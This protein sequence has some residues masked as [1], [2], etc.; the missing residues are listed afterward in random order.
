MGLLKTKVGVATFKGLTL[1]AKAIAGPVGANRPARGQLGV[2]RGIISDIDPNVR[3]VN[4]IDEEDE[5]EAVSDIDKEL[6]ALRDRLDKLKEGV[7]EE[8]DDMDFDI[9]EDEANILAEHFNLPPATIKLEAQR[10]SSYSSKREAGGSLTALFVPPG[11]T[12]KRTY[13]TQKSEWTEQQENL[14]L[15][16]EAALSPL[17]PEDTVNSIPSEASHELDDSSITTPH[18]KEN[19]LALVS[20]ELDVTA[21]DTSDEGGV[22]KSLDV[23]KPD[24]M[25]TLRSLKGKCT[26]TSEE[27]SYAKALPIHRF[28]PVVSMHENKASLT[29]SSLSFGHGRKPTPHPSD[30]GSSSMA[31]ATIQAGSVKGNLMFTEEKLNTIVAA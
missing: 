27:P 1:R 14:P 8:D 5:T 16:S 31:P 26:V 17:S 25:S 20:N 24:H 11:S 12:V 19:R 29:P 6:A 4:R 28:S 2:Q 23:P 30:D 15:E 3:P 13:T 21:N 22:A 18:V 9:T 7:D 10:L